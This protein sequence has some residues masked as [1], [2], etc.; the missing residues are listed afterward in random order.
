MK[1]KLVILHLLLCLA[2]PQSVFAQ[3]G[4]VSSIIAGGGGEMGTIGQ[5]DSHATIGGRPALS[6]GF[7][8]AEELPWLSIQRTGNTLAFAWPAS[9]IGFQLEQSEA[10]GV[11]ALWDRVAQPVHVENGENQITI[12]IGPGTRFFRLSK[13]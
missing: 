1:G 10:A 2:I 3:A 5:W 6:S 8:N 11:G 12:L 13:P 7:W 9:F 4:I